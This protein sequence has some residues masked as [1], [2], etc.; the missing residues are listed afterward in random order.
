VAGFTYPQIYSVI[1]DSEHFQA[2]V[3]ERFLDLVKD[4]LFTDR[5]Q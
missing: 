1:F 2:S 3:A 4:L 5:S